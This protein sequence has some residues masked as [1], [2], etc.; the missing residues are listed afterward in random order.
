MTVPFEVVVEPGRLTRSG[1]GSITGPLVVR[2]GEVVFPAAEWH[3]FPVVVL[4]WWLEE[5][6]RLGAKGIGEFL[7]MDG[8][9][10]FT[11]HTNRDSGARVCFQER[12]VAGTYPIAEAAVP[13]ASVIS[14]IES[15]AR[16]VFVT[17]Q[18]RGWHNDDVE[19]FR[20]WIA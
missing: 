13:V 15:A 2:A 6:R 19:H 18:G 17:C 12:Q 4:S 9:F 1:T 10:L 11:V 14:A 3:D 20:R 7:F 16:G 8:P 5:S